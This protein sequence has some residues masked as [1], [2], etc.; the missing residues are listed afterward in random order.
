METSKCFPREAGLVELDLGT[1]S[2][3]G[4]AP[5]RRVAVGD[6]LANGQYHSSKTSLDSSIL[7]DKLL[8]P[9]PSDFCCINGHFRIGGTYHIYGLFFR[10]M[11]VN[12]PTNYGLM[13]STSN[14]GSWNDHWLYAIKLL[15]KKAEVCPHCQDEQPDPDPLAPPK[16]RRGWWRLGNNGFHQTW[17]VLPLNFLFKGVLYNTIKK[18]G[19][20]EEVWIEPLGKWRNPAK[21]WL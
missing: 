11:Q 9:I 6:L 15:V 20:T 14:L 17:E 2:F 3:L 1:G 5:C 21:A 7:G 19:S 4:E 13:Y 12:T 18:R 16:A 10:P 8:I